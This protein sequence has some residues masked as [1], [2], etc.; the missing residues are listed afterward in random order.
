MKYNHKTII[1]WCE[2]HDCIIDLQYGKY[3]LYYNCSSGKCKNR[4]CNIEEK[5][6]KEMIAFAENDKGLYK[7]FKAKK[8]HL[9]IDIK[10]VTKEAIYI[11]ID[12]SPNSRKREHYGYKY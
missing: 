11:H 4:L 7:G 10:D 1:F 3:G 12:R 2:E 5:Y 9:K 8:E 6:L